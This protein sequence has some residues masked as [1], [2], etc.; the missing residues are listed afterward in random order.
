MF[1][2]FHST[3]AFEVSIL[4]STLWLQ[5]PLSSTVIFSFA[6]FSSLH[7]FQWFLNCS[8]KTNKETTQ[9]PLSISSHFSSPLM[10]FFLCPREYLQCYC[11]LSSIQFLLLLPHKV[12][13]ISFSF[14]SFPFISLPH[15]PSACLH[16]E[17]GCCANVFYL[18]WGIPFV[19]VSKVCAACVMNVYFNVSRVMKPPVPS[20]PWF[21]ILPSILYSPVKPLNICHPWQEL[22]L[23]KQLFPLLH[24]PSFTFS[25]PMPSRNLWRKGKAHKTDWTAFPDNYS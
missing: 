17:S 11:Q 4:L 1:P 21:R 7:H 15:V 24:L 5:N 2:G 19:D 22:P 10:L 20:S 16:C 25:S 3:P 14:F 18:V 9:P 6:K 23:S 8:F 13:F 12:L